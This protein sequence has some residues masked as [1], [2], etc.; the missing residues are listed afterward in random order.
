MVALSYGISMSLFAV[1]VLETS[2]N[3]RARMAVRGSHQR[4]VLLTWRRILSWT[5]N[6][7]FAAQGIIGLATEQPFALISVLFALY[8]TYMEI[9]NHK[10]DDDWFNGRMKKVWKG[11]KKAFTV[12]VRVPSPVA[13][14]SPVFG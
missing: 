6:V 3:V 13:A 7:G 8:L 1:I 2:V 9:K 4:Y 14:P 12:K 10:D 5:V 11:V